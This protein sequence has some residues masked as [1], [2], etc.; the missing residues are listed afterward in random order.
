[1]KRVIFVDDEARILEGLRRML[2]P[3]RN[4]WEMA[5]A[6]GGQAALDVMA[7]TPFDVIVSDMRMP[8]MDGAALLEQVREHYPE[9]IRIVLSGHTEMATALRVVPIAHQFLAKPCDAETRFISQSNAPVTFKRSSPTAPSAPWLEHWEICPP[10]HARMQP[11]I[12][13]WSTPTHPF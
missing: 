1:M 6:P 9:V 5:F 8:G 4:Q 13:C 2:R 10:C 7:T 3:M 12:G 11:S